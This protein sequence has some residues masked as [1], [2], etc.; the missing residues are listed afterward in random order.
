MSQQSHYHASLQE[1]CANEACEFLL[2]DEKFT[3]W[4]RARES[5]QLAILGDMGYGKT[6]CMAF[7]VD[8]LRRRSVHQLPQPKLCYYYC[9]DDESGQA[10]RILSALILALLEQLSGLKKTFVEWYKQAQASGCFEPATNAKKLEEFLHLVV[11]GLDRQL[12]IVIDGLDECDR[13]SRTALLN[14]LRGLMLRTPRLKI[15]LS[16]RPHE[17]ILEQL[18]DTAPIDLVSNTERDRAIATKTVELRLSYLPEDVKALVIDRLS[19]M[20]QGNSIWTR[21]IVELIE[22]RRIRAHG[23]MSR[24]LNGQTL[25]RGL[26]ELYDTLLSR[27]TSDDL[28]NLELAITALRI[29]AVARRAL[30]ILELS[31]AATLGTADPQ[32][33]T[34]ASLAELV[35]HQR[36][37]SLIQP[38]ISR[39]DFGDVTKRQIRLV[40]QSVKEWILDCWA[41]GVPRLEKSCSAFPPGEEMT[42]PRAENL[43]SHMLNICIRYLLLDEI[44]KVDIFSEEQMALEILPQESDLFSDD[45]NGSSGYTVNCSWDDW[46]EG[47][48]RYDPTERGLGHLFVYASCHWMNHFGAITLDPLPDLGRIES[49]CRPGSKRL[50]NWIEQNR[51]PGC[52]IAPRFE[53]DSTLYDPLGI[54]LMYGSDAMLRHMLDTSDFEGDAFLPQSAME[55]VSQI[56]RWADLSRLRT[57]V[58]ESKLKDQIDMIDFFRLLIGHWALYR[59]WRDD[60]DL[61]FELVDELVD[62]LVRDQCANE[63]LCI[64][65]SRGCMP[66][67]VR[68]MATS[69]H[70]AELRRE[71]LHG[72]RVT[73]QRPFPALPVH[74]SIGEAVLADRVDVVE[75]LLQEGIE[76][77]VRHINSRGE[78]VLHLASKVCNP[79]MFRKLIPHLPDGVHQPDNQGDTP[80]LRVVKNRA[81]TQD[82]YA[83]AAILLTEGCALEPFHSVHERQALLSTAV[84]LGDRN[85]CD[86]LVRLGGIERLPDGS[87]SDRQS[88]NPRIS[89]S[90]GEGRAEDP[91]E[92]RRA[93]ANAAS[94]VGNSTA[95]IVRSEEQK[96]S[97]LNGVPGQTDRGTATEDA[98]SVDEVKLMAATALPN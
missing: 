58:L 45:E 69:R 31:W 77:H 87:S 19:G 48:I 72:T 54:T 82:R 71:L 92:L 80:L 35:D 76:A 22:R 64:A 84:E 98:A 60:W 81:A 57:V 10:S 23:L 75:Y 65:A 18:A 20:A 43:E 74:Q 68:L 83:S 36:L 55:A 93:Q 53:F 96:L 33:T 59:Q 51:R 8:T 38:F 85:M 49:L 3:D 17:E 11:G 25:P 12:F 63:L 32:V 28:E 61:A 34:V 90:E 94:V 9:R 73:E 15:L 42:G 27:C 67:I 30:T 44:D 16:S 88:S 56:I 41:P 91:L 47:M 6:V 26:L 52:A 95:P 46:E 24:F 89:S 78:N 14:I 39:V 5:R 97:V 50:H 21:M 66:V 4:Y 1:V 40:H 37:M 2:Q 7:L 13:A 70:N 29:L 62:T 86:I 79:A